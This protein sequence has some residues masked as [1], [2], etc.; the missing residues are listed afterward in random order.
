MRP[1]LAAMAIV[2]LMIS[3][4]GKEESGAAKS[5]GKPVESANMIKLESGVEYKDIEVGTG[6]EAKEGDVL[7]VHYKGWLDDGTVFD[8]SRKPGA[9]AFSF[10]L[11]A[12]DVI[13]GW[14]KGL[15]GMKVGGM[16]ELK[17][18][19]SLAYGDQ[20]QPNIPANSTLHFTV[21]LLQ[22]GQ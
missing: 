1:T 20:E 7:T 18:P 4:C 2:A 5:S 16:R 3:G 6:P 22:I 14:D 19:P 17:I 10:K 9:S 13:P 8:S 15:V 11:G 21:E 12:G